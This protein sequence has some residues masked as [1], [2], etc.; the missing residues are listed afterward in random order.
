VKTLNLPSHSGADAYSKV[1]LLVKRSKERRTA[2]AKSLS[3]KL[4]KLNHS[5]PKYSAQEL[6]LWW[7]LLFPVASKN[8]EDGRWQQLAAATF[9]I[10]FVAQRSCARFEWLHVGWIQGDFI[11]V[12]DAAW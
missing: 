7:I 5:K 8:A 9:G 10:P 12:V 2:A 1:D 4:T 11:W 3:A 6:K